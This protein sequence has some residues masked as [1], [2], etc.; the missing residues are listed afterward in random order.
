MWG[1]HG[2]LFLPR[3]ILRQILE[4]FFSENQLASKA[5]SC[6]KHPYVAY[7]Q[8]QV[9]LYHDP[10]GMA[11]CVFVAI[12][13]YFYLLMILHCLTTGY[14]EIFPRTGGYQNL[15]SKFSYQ[16]QAVNLGSSR[17]QLPWVVIVINFPIRF[18]KHCFVPLS[19]V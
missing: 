11:H 18:C 15:F 8:I 5:I 9:S 2:A 12:C 19:R 16:V 13:K 14:S 7:M 10:R 3:N 6:V 1:H 17:G 4:I